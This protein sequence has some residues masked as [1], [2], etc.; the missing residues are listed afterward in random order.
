MIAG[1]LLSN[2]IRPLKTTDSGLEA[3]HRMKDFNV[4]SLPVVENN[5]LLGLIS[6]DDIGDFNLDSPIS[7]YG[8]S[9]RNAFIQETDHLYEAI[10]LLGEHKITAVPVVD[11]NMNYIGLITQ[12]DLISFF[13]NIGS[14]SEPGSIIVLE[15]SKV[16]YSLA[17]IS[18]IVESE[19]ATILSTFITTSVDSEAVDVTLKI[20][21]QN[22]DHLLSSLRRYDYKVKASFQELE[23]FD[24]LKERYDSLMNYLNV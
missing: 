17:E 7:F 13:A 21:K 20:N 24:S 2:V 22:I 16:D 1:S 18:R 15:M 3:L 10:R 6:E 12:D 14:F 19:N 23:Y 5:K 8:I 11:K 4:R 9:Y